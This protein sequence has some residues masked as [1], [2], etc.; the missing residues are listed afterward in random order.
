MNDY[1]SRRHARI[2]RLRERSAK[3]HE[4]AR[5][6]FDQADKMASIIPMGQP[7]LVGH[8]SEGRDRNYRERIH[9]KMRRASE[10]LTESKELERR[11]EAAESSR[12][13][14]SD[15]PEAIAKLRVKLA[16]M[17]AESATWKA[18]NAAH[19]RFLKDPA[20]LDGSE[21]SESWKSHVRNYKPQY[22]WEPH[23][24]PPYRFQNLNGNMRRVRE[25]IADLEAKATTQASDAI[26][27]Q[28]WCVE[29]DSIDNRVRIVFD[30][31]PPEEVRSIVKR[32]G[33]RW[34]PTRGAWVRQLNNA[35]RHAAQSIAAELRKR[36][37][38]SE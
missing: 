25:R 36:E 38:P 16:E 3:K 17:E 6:L 26:Q 18:V 23:P 33:F 34:S 4:H 31:I 2:E 12:A 14:S 21:L 19:R 13:I 10:T 29:E 37:Q 32:W 27:G 20:S 30:A 5:S 24:I 28:G 1:E 11:A 7:I 9:N 22:S 15:D 35:A 8:Y